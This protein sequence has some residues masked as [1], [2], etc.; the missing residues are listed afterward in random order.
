LPDIYR[1]LDFRIYLQAWFEARKAVEPSFSRRSF[2][3]LAGKSSPGLLT[4]I[5]NGRQV[6][7]RMVASLVAALGL[8][9]AE[10][11]F[12]HALVQLDQATS[13]SERN[14][15][16]DRITSSRGF[17]KTRPAEGAAVRYFSDWWIRV[18]KELAHRSDFRADPRWIASRLRPP[19]TE[20]QARTALDVLEQ[21]GLLRAGHDGALRST[22]AVVKTPPE[23]AGLAVANYHRSMLERALDGLDGTPPEQRHYLAATVSVP[24]SLTPQLKAELDA[25]HERMLELCGSCEDAAEEVLQM[26]LLLFP[27]TDTAPRD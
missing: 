9:K 24:R 13:S 25:F 22:E 15:A 19:I 8:N 20:A 1:Y 18:V 12:F 27:L 17:Q 6:T 5:I 2:A 3:R 7:E 14:H 23:V 11:D 26:E 21:L 16:W 4:E 10:A